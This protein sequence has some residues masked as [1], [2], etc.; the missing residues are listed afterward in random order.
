MIDTLYRNM[1]SRTWAWVRG[2]QSE[3]LEAHILFTIE[4]QH[5]APGVVDAGTRKVDARCLAWVSWAG[6]LRKGLVRYGYI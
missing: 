6:Y 4:S 2:R 1:Q 3:L 5:E